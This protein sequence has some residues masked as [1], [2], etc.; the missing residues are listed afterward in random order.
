MNVMTPSLYV[1]NGYQLWYYKSSSEKL[2]VRCGFDQKK[3]KKLKG[4]VI[5]PEDPNKPKCPF[6]LRAVKF[7]NEKSLEEKLRMNPNM[8]VVDIQ[9]LIMR[10]Y[11]AKV[12]YHQC[13]GAKRI[14]LYQLK[15]NFEVRQENGLKAFNVEIDKKTCSCRQWQISGIRCPHLITAMYFLG[16]NLDDFVSDAFRLSTYKKVYAFNIKLVKGIDQWR[17]IRHITCLPPTERRMPGRPLVARKKAKRELRKYVARHTRVMTCQNYYQ[18]S[19][20]KATCN[21]PPENK[22]THEPKKQGN[23][24]GSSTSNTSG[25]LGT[26]NT[27]GG[28][29]PRNSGVGS[30]PSN[31]G[32]GS[33]LSN[34]GGGSR[35]NNRGGGSCP[36][37]TCYKGKEKYVVVSVNDAESYLHE[38]PVEYEN[39][40]VEA[41]MDLITDNFELVNVEVV[42]EDARMV[43]EDTHVIDA[44]PHVVTQPVRTRRVSGRLLTNN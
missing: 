10:K 19:H 12:S 27:C 6:R 1:A 42:N 26:N 17:K 28:S 7:K 8:K 4:E 34:R 25:G 36:S 11:R 20:T 2:L 3:P 32:G 15:Q 30:C 41:N 35:P 39:V 44:E 14:A 33:R 9:E 13:S 23:K 24:G 21:N 40:D 22:P 29:C 37:N 38:V 43:D 18:T 5:D 16:N 31:I